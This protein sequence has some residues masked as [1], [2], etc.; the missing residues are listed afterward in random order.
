VKDV[1]LFPDDQIREMVLD[2]VAL[3][4]SE[5]NPKDTALLYYPLPQLYGRQLA[6][7]G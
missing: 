6:D 4:L 2:M 7:L 3:I 1:L 5:I